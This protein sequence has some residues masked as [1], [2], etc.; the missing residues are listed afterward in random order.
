MLAWF[1]KKFGKQQDTPEAA[2]T[3]QLEE[4][5]LAQESQVSAELEETLAADTLAEAEL[6]TGSM[7]A[8]EPAAGLDEALPEEE[9]GAAGLIAAN[10]VA[11]VAADLAADAAADPADTE[12]DKNLVGIDAVSQVETA[13]E[14]AVAIDTPGLEEIAP[15][16]PEV[17]L[18]EADS[19]TETLAPQDAEDAP[20]GMHHM[21]EGQVVIDGEEDPR[22][23]VDSMGEVPLDLE[24]FRHRIAQRRDQARDQPGDRFTPASGTQARDRAG[25][26]ESQATAGRGGQRSVACGQDHHLHHRP[27]LS[28]RDA[29]AVKARHDAGA[30]YRPVA[31]DVFGAAPLCLSVGQAP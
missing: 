31:R 17:F 10:V 7:A 27:A 25:D 12:A 6:A 11:D 24:V 19:A 21:G 29:H 30:D 5:T 23:A 8:T 13:V 22:L 4:Q 18:S 15:P 2:E 3:E 14:A 20:E 26:E 28:R 16:L 1:K 9:P